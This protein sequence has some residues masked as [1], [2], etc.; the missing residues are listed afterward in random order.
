ML[1][2]AFKTLDNLVPLYPSRFF[3]YFYILPRYL[4]HPNHT[5]V[6]PLHLVLLWGGGG[7]IPGR[8]DSMSEREQVLSRSYI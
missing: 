2:M 3:C 6:L 5:Q 1:Y 4:S 8:G 7:S